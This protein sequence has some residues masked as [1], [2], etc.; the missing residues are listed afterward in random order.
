[1]KKKIALLMAIVTLVASML[2]FAGCQ[3]AS[4]A[5]LV[6]LEK[7]ISTEQYGIGFKK[8]NTELRDA[9]QAAVYELYADGTMEKIANEY[10]DYDLNKMVCLDSKNATTF[11]VSKASDEFKARKT[12]TVGFDA[13]YPP[14]G[15]LDGKDYKG[16]D[17]D[18]A[19]KVC[20]KY[21]W[22]LVKTPI[23]W[24]SKDS[25]LDSGAIDVIWNGFTKTGRENDYEWTDAYLDNSIVL[26]TLEDS[27]IKAEA[28]LKDKVVV[29]QQGSSAESALEGDKA[30]L[31][32]TF[33]ELKKVP[34]YNTAFTDLK[35]GAVDAIAVDIGV[36]Q[37]QLANQK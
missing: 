9:V 32:K 1:M 16:F 8:G 35:S 34:D 17:L 33:K 36:A 19:Q 28:D 6:M 2:A 11:D 12:F 4:D 7:P 25:I 15:Y 22:E 24:D 14:Y 23:D 37:Y 26:V 18:L 20:E 29:T 13:E 10:K 27:G 30:E 21:G 31:T 3:K 5:K